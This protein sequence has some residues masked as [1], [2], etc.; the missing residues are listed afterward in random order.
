MTVGYNN[1]V[2]VA[3]IEVLVALG[4][5]IAT[6]LTM[7][8]LG[9]AVGTV[10]L[11]LIVSLERSQVDGNSPCTLSH[12]LLEQHQPTCSMAHRG[13]FGTAVCYTALFA[14]RINA[15]GPVGHPAISSSQADVALA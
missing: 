5:G 1:L 4:R 8:I 13:S 6:H 10:V 14:R 7:T 2:L 15:S 3:V 12:C 11:V 9:C